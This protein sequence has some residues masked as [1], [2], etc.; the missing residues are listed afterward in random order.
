MAVQARSLLQKMEEQTSFFL[1]VQIEKKEHCLQA[2]EEFLSQLEKAQNK[3]AATGSAQIKKDLERAYEIVHTHAEQIDSESTEDIAL[4]ER[5]L[6]S[7]NFIQ[8]LNNPAKEEEFART[9]LEGEEL[10]PTEQFKQEVLVDAKESYNTVEG[11]FENLVYTLETEG[12]KSLTLILESMNADARQEYEETG[13]EEDGGDECCGQLA[14]L[15]EKGCCGAAEIDIFTQLTELTKDSNEKECMMKEPCRCSSKE[16]CRCSGK[17]PCRGSDTEKEK[18]GCEKGQGSGCSGK[19]SCRCQGKEA[20][21]CADAEGCGCDKGQCSS[22]KKEPCCQ[23]TGG[24]TCACKRRE[25]KEP[26]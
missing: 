4:L 15:G 17:E 14:K 20:C 9:L 10:M 21:R 25:R 22:E 12:A 2:Y 13:P 11:M 3:A 26:C 16:P 5:Y 8:T 24:G 1:Q 23:A 18:C 6:E 7:I 19:E